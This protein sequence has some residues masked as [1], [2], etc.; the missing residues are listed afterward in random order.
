MENFKLLRSIESALLPLNAVDNSVQKLAMRIIS[1]MVEKHHSCINFRYVS[2]NCEYVAG[3]H[4][5]APLGTLHWE[6]HY[7]TDTAVVSM[8]DGRIRIVPLSENCTAMTFDKPNTDTKWI[9]CQLAIS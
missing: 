7:A 9:D 3:A 5:T 6:V 4:R 2:Y 8:V 1:D